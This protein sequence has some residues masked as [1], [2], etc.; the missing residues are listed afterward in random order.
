MR[1]VTTRAAL[2]RELAD[3][4]RSDRRIGLVP[5]MGAL[6]EGHLALC[7]QARSLCDVLVLSIFVNPLQFGPGEDLARYPR[8]LDRDRELAAGRGVDLVFA[9]PTAE[10]YP[11]PATRVYVTAPALADRLCG[12]W[13]PGHFDGVLTVVAKLFHV[14]QPA[15]AVFGQK[16]LQQAALVRRM[17]RDLDFPVDVRIG[18]V[19]RDRDGLALSSRNAFLSPEERRS[20]QALPRALFAARD[21]WRAGERDGARLLARARRELDAEPGVRL[22]YLELVDAQSLDR[23]DTAVPGAA[24]AV[25]GHVGA[26]RLIDNVLLD[27]E[28]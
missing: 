12:A 28:T 22:Q 13:R 27:D 16:D 9:P 7:D 3:V 2:G 23:L 20:A 5:T 26:T 14:V 15:V 18:P 4:R 1:V 19:V 10:M 11:E 8:A 17:V 25:A 24:L 21:A 6:H